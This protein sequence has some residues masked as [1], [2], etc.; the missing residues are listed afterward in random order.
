MPAFINIDL[1]V[2]SIGGKCWLLNAK[3]IFV[4]ERG[5]GTLRTIACTHAGSGAL[6]AI[7]GIPNED[8]FFDGADPDRRP[9]QMPVDIESA[10]FN[11]R[12]FYYAN[13]TVMGSWMLDAGFEFGLT[14]CAL[15]GNASTTAFASIV[16]APVRRRLLVA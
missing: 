11:G 1:P 16:W 9:D 5:P 15:G 4:L 2:P 8:G 3:G 14:V 10:A 6:L 13:P 7:D 12:A